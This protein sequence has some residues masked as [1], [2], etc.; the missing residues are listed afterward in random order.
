MKRSD[1][2]D[3]FPEATDEQVKKLMDINGTDVN[4]IRAQLDAANAA[5]KTAQDA[6][7]A[8]VNA[9]DFQK[10]KE[11][12]ETLEQELNALKAENGLREMRETVA[13]EK[14]LPAALLTGGT[15]DECK[16]QADAIL[17]FAKPGAYPS[18]PDGGEAAHHPSASTR[19][20]FA[21]WM[22]NLK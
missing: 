19:D 21:E 20:Q 5:L 4:G 18:L 1:I 15:E 17:A 6:A 8:A 12:A 7:K 11:R 13:K 22:N 10:E 2:T 3:L 16:T 14:G 9:A